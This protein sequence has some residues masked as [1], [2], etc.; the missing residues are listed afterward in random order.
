MSFSKLFKSKKPVVAPK[1]EEPKKEALPARE[2]TPAKAVN[3]DEIKEAVIEAL[4]TVYDPEIPVNVYEMGLVYDID[5]DT[6]G[7]VVVRMTLTSPGCPV[8]ASLPM[9][10]KGKTLMVPGVNEAKIVLVWDPP[11]DPSMMSEAARLQLGFL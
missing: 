10:V 1:A 4:R 5:V 6:A 8:A 9:E 2:E 3:P 7:K 11:W